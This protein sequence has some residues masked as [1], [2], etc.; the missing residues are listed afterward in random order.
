MS[1]F[2]AEEVKPE[3]AEEAVAAVAA[4]APAQEVEL[5]P[6]LKSMP[7][8]QPEEVAEKKAEKKAAKKAAAPGKSYKRG[9]A[10]KDIRTIQQYLNANGF[11]CPETGIFCVHTHD[12]VKKFQK[13]LGVAEDGV[14]TD[15][16]ISVAK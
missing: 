14:I 8:P 15:D 6:T 7:Q 9:D 5:D 11:K 12:A 16:M 4:E 2:S 13:S 3:V 10:G 1:D